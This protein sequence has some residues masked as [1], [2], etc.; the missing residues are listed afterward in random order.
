[1]KFQNERMLKCHQD[2]F[3]E[4]DVLEVVFLLENG[5]VKALHRVVGV[6][7]VASALT[8]LNEEDFGERSFAQQAY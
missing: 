1:M 3:L 5:L 7:S 6:L 8:L 2:L 4:F